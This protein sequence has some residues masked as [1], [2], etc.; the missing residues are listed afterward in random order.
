MLNSFFK[1]PSNRKWTWISR[2]GSTKNKTELIISTKTLKNVSVI[3][4]VKTGS[5][6]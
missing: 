4:M 2:D 1:K 5:G 6:H 3:S